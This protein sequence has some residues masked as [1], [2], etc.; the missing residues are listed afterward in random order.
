M[1]SAPEPGE[2]VRGRVTLPSFVGL[3]VGLRG[4]AQGWS[5]QEADLELLSSL[6][7]Q[8]R[9]VHGEM[10]LSKEGPYKTMQDLWDE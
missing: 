1:E 2:A 10:W 3:L 4:C 6:A 8:Q 9:M 5:L 7:T